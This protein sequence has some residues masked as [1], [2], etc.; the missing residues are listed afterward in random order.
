[1]EAINLMPRINRLL[2]SFEFV[3]FEILLI[4]A[5]IGA[6][7]NRFELEGD[8]AERSA[9]YPSLSEGVASEG[10]LEPVTVKER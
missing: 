5:A 2:D 9:P 7:D 6:N 1:M 10:S 4:M 8:E 3:L